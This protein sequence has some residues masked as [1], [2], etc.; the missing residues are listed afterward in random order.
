[1][2]PFG[3]PCLWFPKT[4]KK[5]RLLHLKP[6]FGPLLTTASDRIS[7]CPSIWMPVPVVA[8]V[9]LSCHSENNVPVVGKSRNAQEPRHALV[10]YRSLLLQRRN[11]WWGCREKESAEGWFTGEA[12][13]EM[14]MASANPQVAFQPVMSALQP[15][16]LETVCP[17]AATS[18]GRQV[19]TKWHTTVVLERVTV[20]ITV[21]IKCV[22]STGS[23]MPKTKN[24]ITTWTT[25]W[26]VWYSI[27]TW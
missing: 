18:H 4:M 25:I 20:R 10:A 15:C 12:L 16:T 27:Q 21:L 8:L 19:K 3:T 17:V 22:D 5:F 11:L 2:L 24:L 26:A 6:I 1:M 9:S 14:E 23:F 13:R 7:T